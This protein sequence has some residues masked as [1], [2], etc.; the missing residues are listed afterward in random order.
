MVYGWMIKAGAKVGAAGKCY[1]TDRHND[2]DV[3]EDREVRYT[4]TMEKLELRAHVWLYIT[5]DEYAALKA[6]HAK[7][8]DHGK[9][10]LPRGTHSD[11][12]LL[13]HVDGDSPPP[14]L[15]F[16]L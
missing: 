5:A 10:L 7:N 8:K 15:L 16:A 12:R 6:A 11:G 1:Y 14:A 2:P 13:F 4:P 3:E 9:E